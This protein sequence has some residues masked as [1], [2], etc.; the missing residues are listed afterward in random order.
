MTFADPWHVITYR[1][2]AHEKG[3]TFRGLPDVLAMAWAAGAVGS[4]FVLCLTVYAAVISSTANHGSWD[5][6]VV[7]NDFSRRRYFL[8]TLTPGLVAQYALRRSFTIYSDNIA[9]ATSE[10]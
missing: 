6:S 2:H 3:A 9:F 10:N 4:Y 1:W 5:A 7:H 8:A